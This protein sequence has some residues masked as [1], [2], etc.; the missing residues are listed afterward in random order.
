MSDAIQTLTLEDV[1]AAARKAYDEKR[2]LAQH[3]DSVADTPNEM[4]AT[5]DGHCCAVGA[6]L[7]DATI[8]MLR[9]S[10]NLSGTISGMVGRGQIRVSPPGWKTQ[11]AITEIMIAHDRMIS[12]PHKR[13]TLEASFL[14]LIDHS[15]ASPTKE[16]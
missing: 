4:F 15:A 6:A 1:K 11:D 14:K 10:G 3:Y 5:S 7:S 2:L 16:A 8:A 9:A 12:E 13:R